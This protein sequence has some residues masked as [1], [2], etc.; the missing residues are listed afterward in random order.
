MLGFSSL[1]PMYPEVGKQASKVHV[2][3]EEMPRAREALPR[4]ASSSPPPTLASSTRQQIHEEFIALLTSGDRSRYGRAQQ[5][6]SKFRTPLA[7]PAEPSRP[8]KLDALAVYE[9]KMDVEDKAFPPMRTEPEP[10]K[11]AIEVSVREVPYYSGS[12][13]GAFASS[14]EPRYVFPR[15][16]DTYNQAPSSYTSLLSELDDYLLSL[17]PAASDPRTASVYGHR[18]STHVV[19]REWKTVEEYAAFVQNI[20]A[21]SKTRY[22]P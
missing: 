6:N 15:V 3:T 17:S 18:S 5:V 8:A 13:K 22:R 16:R 2:R 20:L 14:D 9:A 19:A 21:D 1:A 4:P 11:K 7:P 10:K 12:M